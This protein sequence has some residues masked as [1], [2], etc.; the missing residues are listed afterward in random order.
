MADTLVLPFSNHSLALSFSSLP[1]FS[2]TS[3]SSFVSM[4]IR[5]YGMGGVPQ[6]TTSLALLQREHG[7]DV[8]AETLCKETLNFGLMEVRFDTTTV[9]TIQ[10]S[11]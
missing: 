2:S 6:I 1:L 11:T 9:Y 4:H 10:C 5:I 7:L 8:S 3:H